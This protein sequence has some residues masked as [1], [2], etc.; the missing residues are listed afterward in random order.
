MEVI[1]HIKT[2][3]DGLNY[4]IWSYG[5]SSFLKGKRLWRTISSSIINL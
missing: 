3:L 5:M 4:A 1:Q 2:T